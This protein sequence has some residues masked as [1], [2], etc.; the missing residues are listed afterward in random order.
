M[1][2]DDE[3]RVQIDRVRHH[4]RTEHARRQQ[5]GFGAV[6]TRDQ[7]AE[8]IAGRRGLQD[9]SGEEADH[10]DRE[11]GHDHPLEDLLLPRVLQDQDDHGHHADDQSADHQRQ[12]EQ[13][14][15]S[16]SP[17]HDLG[18]IGCRGDDLGLH[19]VCAA[20]TRG[21]APAEQ[22]GQAGSG[23][24]AEFGRLVLDDHGDQIGHHQNPHE[25]ESVA[26]ARGDIGGHIA[27]VHVGDRGDEGGSE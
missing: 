24:D 7:T 3:R 19:P 17:A 21:Q 23:D 8:Y 5:H 12:V 15:Q 4:R 14:L 20:G 11:H 25:Q 1:S 26:G 16:D 9:E 27:R 2:I 22:R 18:Q 6:E 10:D 13:Q